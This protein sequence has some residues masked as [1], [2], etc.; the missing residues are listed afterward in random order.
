MPTDAKL[1][2][3]LKKIGKC[4]PRVEATT[5]WRRLD[6]AG[7]AF[8]LCLADKISN[9]PVLEKIHNRTAAQHIDLGPHECVFTHFGSSAFHAYT[10]KAKLGLDGDRRWYEFELK[11]SEHKGL[12]G[13]RLLSIEESLTNSR[14]NARR[15]TIYNDAPQEI[16][17]KLLWI[18][19]LLFWSLDS[20]S[21]RELC[22]TLPHRPLELYDEWSRELRELIGSD[23]SD[24]ESNQSPLT[25]T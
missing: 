5:V 2:N 19:E 18:A 1:W 10:M 21:G 6:G 13:V 20:P 3:D 11:Y 23:D 24:V 9:L 12:L 25:D 15:T 16:R 8:E 4:N 7:R 22:A 14:G 17:G